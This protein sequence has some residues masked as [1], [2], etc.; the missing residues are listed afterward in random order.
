MRKV[1]VSGRELTLAVITGVLEGALLGLVLSLVFDDWSLLAWFAL[2][3]PVQKVIVM[4]LDNY[5][6]RQRDESVD[7]SVYLN[8]PIASVAV[9]WMLYN[10][11]LGIIDVSQTQAYWRLPLYAAAGALLGLLVGYISK[12]QWNHKH[13]DSPVS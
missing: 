2:G 7:G 1:M 4:L 9:Q 10:T 8:R 11:L 13:A 6:A 3:F 5:F 12:R